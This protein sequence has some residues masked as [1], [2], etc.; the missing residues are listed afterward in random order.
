MATI[1]RSDRAKVSK[2]TFRGRDG[3]ELFAERWLPSKAPAAIVQ[4]AHGVSEHK[5]RYADFAASLV[6]Q[7]FGVYANDHRG[8]GETAGSVE[9]LGFFAEKE[10]WEVVV[11]DMHLLSVRAREE[12]PGVPLFLLGHSMGSLLARSYVILHGAELAGALFSGTAGSAGLLGFIG[13]FITAGE[14]RKHGARALSPKLNNL[15]M[16]ANNKKFEPKR[17]DFDWLSR[18]TSV[19]DAYIA[20][21]YCGFVPSAGFF[22]DLLHG[23]NRIN[24]AKEIAKTPREIPILFF[25]GEYDPVGDYTKGVSQVVRKFKR[26]G[27]RDVTCRFY[28][29]CRHECLNELNRDEV[30]GDVIDWITAHL[31]RP[32]GKSR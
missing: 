13:G 32:A 28:K 7:G 11:D 20:D 23:L 29:D 30:Y 17:T 9:A 22:A 26:V 21:P 19:V 14:I 5:E 24:A 16:G 8:H 15:A 4:I 2:F 18:D 31:G 27:M 1:R 10:G 25:S 6:E 3:K 12:H